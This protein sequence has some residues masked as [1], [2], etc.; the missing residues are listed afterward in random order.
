MTGM[1]ETCQCGRPYPVAVLQRPAGT[2]HPL[3][4]ADDIEFLLAVPPGQYT[5]DD[6][7]RRYV[8]HAT[9]AGRRPIN[10]LSLSIALTRLPRFSRS[11]STRQR[12]WHAA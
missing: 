10:R 9:A 3:L 5:L 4:V 1:E 11:R 12:Y 8:E 2:V 7:H 6:I